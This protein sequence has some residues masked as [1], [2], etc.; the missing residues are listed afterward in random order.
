MV[1]KIKNNVVRSRVIA[2][3]FLSTVNW[4]VMLSYRSQRKG[5]LKSLIAVQKNIT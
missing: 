2:T 4:R 3:D 5:Q 1:C